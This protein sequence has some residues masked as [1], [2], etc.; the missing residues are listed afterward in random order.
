MVLDF[1]FRHWKCPNRGTES[2]EKAIL[3]CARIATSIA[4]NDESLV[5]NS[6][7]QL[8]RYRAALAAKKQ[9]EKPGRSLI[10]SNYT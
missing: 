8:G 4:L 1:R 7:T 3:E 9:T 5:T 2:E 6:L 10:S